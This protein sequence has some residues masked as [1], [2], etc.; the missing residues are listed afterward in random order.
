MLVTS[1]SQKS[2]LYTLRE[3]LDDR[4]PC[5]DWP[6]GAF[7]LLTL[8]FLSLLWKVKPYVRML[9]TKNEIIS[10]TMIIVH[11]IDTSQIRYARAHP[12]LDC[13]ESIGVS[14]PR[15][16]IDGGGQLMHVL[17]KRFLIGQAVG[18]S[19]WAYFHFFC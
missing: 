16:W 6:E 7:S 14:R 3:R 1:E 5:K 15:G 8:S 19:S 10:L 4:F 18:E 11:K 12:A 17:R 2:G 13:D 9:G